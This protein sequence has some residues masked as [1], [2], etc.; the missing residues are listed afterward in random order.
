MKLLKHSKFGIIQLA[1]DYLSFSL[2]LFPT[3]TDDC[4]MSAVGNFSEVQNGLSILLPPYS[5]NKTPFTVENPFLEIQK[6][7]FPNSLPPQGKE[8]DALQAF[9]EQ[10][11]GESQCGRK[12]H[13]QDFTK[14]EVTGTGSIS[15]ASRTSALAHIN[16]DMTVSMA[17][18]YFLL[19]FQ[20]TPTVSK[21]F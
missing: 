3:W 12:F 19:L 16:S 11:E 5:G 20:P 21:L 10:K 4:I 2:F 13:P 1:V 15:F 8:K 6:S 7:G 14:Q 18:H 17:L 9:S